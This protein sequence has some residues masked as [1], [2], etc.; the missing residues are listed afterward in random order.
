MLVNSRGREELG[1]T[2]GDRCSRIIRWG[3][4]GGSQWKLVLANFSQFVALRGCTSEVNSH[5]CHRLRILIGGV[6]PR[7]KLDMLNVYMTEG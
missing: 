4:L 3:S 1:R 6:E 2:R 5:A 7:T